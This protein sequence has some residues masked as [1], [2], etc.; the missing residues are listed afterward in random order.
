MRAFSGEALAFLSSKYLCLLRVLS[1]SLTVRTVCGKAAYGSSRAAS[2]TFL[3]SGLPCPSI[4]GL[5]IVI[6]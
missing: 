2:D 6:K 3:P 5:L 4:T 1:A